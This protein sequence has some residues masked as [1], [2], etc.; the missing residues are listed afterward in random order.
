VQILRDRLER[1]I[2]MICCSEIL[3]HASSTMEGH[4][5]VRIASQSMA[6]VQVREQYLIIVARV[7]QITP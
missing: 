4:R 7:Q 6:G 1:A 5:P 2:S 3:P